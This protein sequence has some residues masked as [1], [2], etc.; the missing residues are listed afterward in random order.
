MI[1]KSFHIGILG[2]SGSLCSGSRRISTTPRLA[3]RYAQVTRGGGGEMAGAASAE[4]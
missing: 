4:A 2:V 3:N 1:R